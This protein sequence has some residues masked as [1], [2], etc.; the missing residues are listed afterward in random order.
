MSSGRQILVRDCV[1]FEPNETA[2][3]SESND[4]SLVGRGVFGHCDKPTQN[5]RI[6]AKRLIEREIKKF[7]K[8]NIF[9]RKM[10]RGELE[11]PDDA[12]TDLK[13]VS[14]YIPNL[15]VEDNGLV[16][17]E[18]RVLE[19][20]RNGMQLKGI[21]D[22]GCIVGVSSR[23][24]GS[25][26]S[27]GSGNVKVG[28]DYDLIAYDVVD[29]P[30]VENALPEFQMESKRSDIID[31]V[32]RYAYQREDNV[33]SGF[34]PENNNSDIIESNQNEVAMDLKK[35]KDEY[36]EKYK[37]MKHE[38][39]KE[40]KDEY[41]EYDEYD[42]NGKK[43]KDEYPEKYKEMKYEVYKE[44]KGEYP[45][46]DMEY[47]EMKGEYPDD[48]YKEE[49]ANEFEK[50]LEQTKSK[51]KK[52]Y[53]EEDPDKELADTVKESL[54]PL[55][56]ESMDVD[57]LLERDVQ[58]LRAENKNLRDRLDEKTSL[59]ERKQQEKMIYEI[60]AK[61]ATHLS[62][63]LEGYR[64]NF[65]GLVG[66]PRDYSSIDKFE[67]KL[68][69][70]VE[71]FEQRDVYIEDIQEVVNENIDFRSELKRKDLL[72]HKANESLK[73]KEQMSGDLNDAKDVVSS[74]KERVKTYQN[75][76][77]EKNSLI[78][79]AVEEIETLESKTRS[80]RSRVSRLQEEKDEKEDELKKYKMKAK[81]KEK[82]LDDVE[83]EKEQMEVEVARYKEVVGSSTPNKD[84]N[85]TKGARSKREVKE[86]MNNRREQRL[87]LNES[88]KPNSP[89]KHG[90]E[91]N[92]D[93]LDVSKTIKEKIKKNSAGQPPVVGESNTRHKV[94]SNRRNRK[95]HTSNSGLM[96]GKA[97]S[98]SLQNMIAE[99]INN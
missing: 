71:D 21:L 37:E 73:E 41:D 6:Y 19:N 44:M 59:A 77:E 35:M 76:V 2:I 45:E 62:N 70:V 27:V 95:K 31:Q 60:K 16:L 12:Y 75:K 26:E 14:H 96:S 83:D 13:R 8:N 65:L 48:K 47:K 46:K 25:T 24:L 51:A 99:R 57:A 52:D 56:K 38:V 5:G 18:L 11:H 32:K 50:A 33:W 55:L 53:D 80:L 9:E 42:D 7:K 97:S 58:E 49:L 15:T 39:Y 82:E 67:E 69:S 68:E 20:T 85:V 61:T 64:D 22:A 40:M 4:G 30:S 1:P 23:G 79:E 72:L 29:D 43:M 98:A 28:D 36:P 54:M 81:E 66:D 84:L 10:F 17:G 86:R 63:V 94:T 78:E 3:L 89:A 34:V 93:D 87:R 92:F 88:R 74:L 91:G 90:D